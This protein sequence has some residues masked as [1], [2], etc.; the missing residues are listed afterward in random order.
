MYFGILEF[1]LRM[2]Q[3][4]RPKL[5][6]YFN[7]EQKFGNVK[8]CHHTISEEKF[9]F[10]C[11]DCKRDFINEKG[12]KIHK[13]RIHG[14]MNQSFLC[15][16]FS[17]KIDKTR[18]KNETINQTPSTSMDY[19]K[20][21]GSEDS[22]PGGSQRLPCTL[23]PGKSFKDNNRLK[24][25]VDKY[26][27]DSNLST[28]STSSTDSITKLLINLKHQL[29]TIRRLT[30]ACRHLAADK[31]SS[32]I[33]NCL[34]TKSISSFENLLLFS[35]RTFNVAEKY[36]K[37]LKKHIKENLSNFDG[38]KRPDGMSLVPWITGQL[39]VWDVT[40]V[41]T[42]ADSYVLKTS[43]VSGFAAEMACKRKH[44]KYSSIIS[45][46]YIFKGLAFETL[47][48]WCKEAID[49]INVIGN[50]LIAESG[51]SKSKKFLFE[52]ISLAIQRGNAV[53]IPCTFP[54][55]ALL[56]IFVL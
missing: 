5:Y 7:L 1:H 31:L 4:C 10:R 35:Y 33:N 11:E 28:S 47:G 12:L 20:Q 29:P 51:D 45:S 55:S 41:D 32:I 22:H 39:L 50:R 40:I 19:E 38:G 23:C 53:S 16:S 44:S 2:R 24:I 6:N 27:V 43:E 14:L 46:S 18:R 13:T 42:L 15:E 48:P 34:L 30:K 3:I 36:D 54:D 21:F 17:S 8:K 26:H 52:R 25:H 9:V 49:F 56:E 37:S